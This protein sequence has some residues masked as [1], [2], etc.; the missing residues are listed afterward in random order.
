[1]RGR[2]MLSFPSPSGKGRDRVFQPSGNQVIAHTMKLYE[3][4]N[5]RLREMATISWEQLLVRSTMD[6]IFTDGQVVE[7]YREKRR[8]CYLAF[9]DLYKAFD[10][11]PRQVL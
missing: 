11:L 2:A 9:L 5:S 3:M 10:R 4:V 8:L 7:K 6:A 1:M